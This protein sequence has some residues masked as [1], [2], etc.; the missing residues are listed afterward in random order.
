VHQVIGR[1]GLATWL[2]EGEGLGELAERLRQA[3]G[4]DMVAAFGTALH[5]SALDEAALDRSIAPYRADPRWRW[6]RSEPSLE[7]V[8]IQLMAQSQKDQP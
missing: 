6:Q 2:V 3:A 4:V 8:F 5:V 1:S 7:D